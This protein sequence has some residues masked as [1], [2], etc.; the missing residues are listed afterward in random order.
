MDIKVIQ[1]AAEDKIDLIT[2]TSIEVMELIAKAAWNE[3]I[4][5]VAQSVE[6]RETAVYTVDEIRKLKK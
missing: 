6:N 3:A 4:E 2:S 1:K 5:A